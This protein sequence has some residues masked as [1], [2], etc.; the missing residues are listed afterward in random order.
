VS[1]KM[2]N[3]VIASTLIAGVSCDCHAVNIKWLLCTRCL[4][5]FVC[6]YIYG[7]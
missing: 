3:V 6:S 5:Q 2:S 1:D 4:Q 7:I